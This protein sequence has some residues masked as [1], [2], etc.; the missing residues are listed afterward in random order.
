MNGPS[1]VPVG[2]C[3]PASPCG[4]AEPDSYTHIPDAPGGPILP[5]SATEAD[6][7]V[8]ANCAVCAYRPEEADTEIPGIEP[9][10]CG[11]NLILIFC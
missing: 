2:P 6:S 3:G 8:V 9:E 5:F 11:K 1:T 4:P 7:T 10:P